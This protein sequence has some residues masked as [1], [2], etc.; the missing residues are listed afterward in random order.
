MAHS[1][2]SFKALI[3]GHF[4]VK[5]APIIPFELQ[6][7]A[8]A[9][10]PCPPLPHNP[11]HL[12]A[13]FQQWQPFNST[14][15]VP[16]TLGSASYI[17]TCLILTTGQQHH[18]LISPIGKLRCKQADPPAHAGV[19]GRAGARTLGVLLQMHS[20]NCCNQFLGSVS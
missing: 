11:H 15:Y 4:S 2:T 5:L 6:F 13:Q 9:S 1:I 7:Q 20:L 16:G 12:L 10:T 18:G 14:Y 8:P 17:L 19:R 3:S